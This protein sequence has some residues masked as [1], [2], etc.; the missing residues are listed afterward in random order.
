[1]IGKPLYSVSRSNSPIVLTLM[2][3]GSQETFVDI[4]SSAFRWELYL[5]TASTKKGMFLKPREKAYRDL[6]NSLP[7]ANETNKAATT[8]KNKFT[9]SVV[10]SIITAREKDRRVY[11]ASTEAAPIIA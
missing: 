10:S 11:P 5:G 9:F 2:R 7:T 1:M 4:I 8:G 3:L 6:L